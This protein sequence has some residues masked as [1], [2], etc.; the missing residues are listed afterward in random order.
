MKSVMKKPSYKEAVERLNLNDRL[1]AAEA[2]LA[3][4]KSEQYLESLVG[5]IGADPLK[6]M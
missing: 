5:T 6:A 4:V 2:K 1:D 3:E